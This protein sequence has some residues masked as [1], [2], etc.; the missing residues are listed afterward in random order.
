MGQDQ[1]LLL[2]CMLCIYQDFWILKQDTK[3]SNNDNWDYNDDDDDDD[4]DD[5]TDNI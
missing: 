3:N 5:D 4:D 1:W 2:L